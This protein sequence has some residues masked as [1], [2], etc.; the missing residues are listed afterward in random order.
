MKSILTSAYF[1]LLGLS[2]NDLVDHKVD[3]ITTPNPYVVL[4]ERGKLT[5]KLTKKQKKEMKCLEENIFWE[6]G[7]QGFKGMTAVAHVVLNRKEAPGYPEDICKIVYQEK[8]FSWTI[9]GQHPRR[10]NS[11]AAQEAREQA[12]LVAGA[13][14][15]GR[16]YLGH[17]PTNG[18][19]MFHSARL[20]KPPF[21]ARVFQKTTK[22]R[23]HI[24]YKPKKSN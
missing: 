8:Q 19:T 17:D 1:V 12:R 16:E 2:P 5:S 23:D 11:D 22:I 14:V 7:N 15:L 20:E 10:D 6:A 4:E 13:A 3:L 9:P 18:A 24:F 21:W